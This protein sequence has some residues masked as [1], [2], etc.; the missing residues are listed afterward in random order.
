MR[1]GRSLVV[2]PPVDPAGVV[3]TTGWVPVSAGA[4]AVISVGAGNDYGHPA[5]ATLTALASRGFQILRTDL[6]G[7]IAVGRPGGGPLLVS[8]RGP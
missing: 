6:D 5:A 8:T 3:T 7:D 1:S 4:V 2:S